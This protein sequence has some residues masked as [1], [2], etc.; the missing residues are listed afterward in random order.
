MTLRY[1]ALLVLAFVGAAA[2]P[3]SAQSLAHQRAL[4]YLQRN[5]ARHG[6][7]E[8]DVTG[9]VV[10]DATTSRRSGVTHVY[11]RQQ[12]GGVPVVAGAMTVNVARDGRVLLASGELVPALALRAPR[13]G[14][15]ISPAQAAEALAADIG[16]APTE[17]FSTVAAKTVGTPG[18]YLSDGGVSREPV[19]AS[20][21]YAADASGALRLAYEVQ[22]AERTAPLVWLGTVDAATGQVLSRV[23]LVIHDAFDG[24]DPAAVAVPVASPLVVAPALAPVLAPMLPVEQEQNAMGGAA[25]RVYP[26]PVI[27]PI[28]TAPLPPADA[29]STV[30]GIENATAS[31]Y[32]WHDTNGAAG[33]EH[34]TTRGNNAWAYT[35][36]SDN[37]T[38]DPSPN[39][40]PD[41]GAALQFVFPLDLAQAPSAYRPAAVTN[42]F[43]WSNLLHD[44]Y[45]Q[46][47]FDEAGGN[48]QANQYGRGGATTDDAVRSEAQDGSGTNNA[49]FYT[50]ID[51]GCGTLGCFPRM[52]MY[53][54]TTPTP[55]VDG[56]FDN[57]VIAHEY[58]HGLS[59]RLTGGP[60]T[61]CL[62]NTEQMGEGWS[63][64]YGLMVTMDATDTRTEARTVGN[65]LFGQGTTGAGIRPAPYSTAFTTNNY[66]YQ[67]TRTAVAPHG[68]GFIWA[69][70]LWEATW[71]MIAAYGFSPD[72]YNADGTAGNQIM[73][74]LVTEAL[75]MQPC[76]P[77]FVD[78]RNA[79]LAADEALYN[80][81]HVD[82]LWAAF[83]RRGLGFGANQGSPD[84]NTD[85]TES[86]I[87]P[88]QVAPAAITDLAVVPNGDY[89]R[90]TFTATGDDGS[91][92]T[93][94][95]YRVRRS[96]APIL[97]DA[98]YEAATPVTVVATPAVAGTAEAI[99]V[100]GLAFGTTYHFA[101]K[102]A[103]ESFNLSALSNS[104]GTT[105]LAA[106]TATVPSGPIS[107][108]TSGEATAML[109]L[110]NAGPSDLR[111][112]LALEETT[113]RTAPAAPTG[114]AVEG[115]EREKDNDP[116]AGAAQLRGS[117]GPDA[118]GYRW[119]DS[120]EPGG[121]AYSWVD[122][123]TTGTALAFSDDD[124]ETV[125]LPFAFPYYGVDQSTVTISSNGNLQFGGSSTAYSNVAI[126]N[127]AVPNNMVA[128]FWDDLNPS[129]TGTVKYQNMG[130]GRFIVQ[131][132]NVPRYTS[133]TGAITAQVILSRSGAIT[134]QYQAVPTTVNSAT[135]GIENATGT[136]GL[137][138]AFDGAYVAANL[139]VRISALWVET[140][141]TAGLIPAGQSRDVQLL[142]DATGL[143]A[144]TYTA[145][146]TV[147]TNSPNAASTV[148]PVTL[149]VGAVAA[150]AGPL[151][152]EG[153]HLLGA[154][155]PNPAPGAS[156]VD[157]AVAEAQTVRVELYDALGRR[158]AVVFDGPVAARTSVPVEVSS[159]ALAA[160]TY[161]LRVVGETF[162][163]ARRVTVVR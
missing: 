49:N 35:D 21:V 54:G 142:F 81:D 31:P 87:E 118:F 4:D 60:T 99:V 71:V 56:D 95:T 154:V 123:S 17:S 44:I 134:L 67:R 124:T 61:E 16:L 107:V 65:Y 43:Y 13:G 126:P 155:Y 160:G 147:T 12:I 24:D 92:G 42:L 141:V 82:L 47:G 77:G 20:L 10:T 109:T 159:G 156:R 79:I 101:L 51:G 131:Y 57:H 86:F 74:N 8:A 162:T 9:L 143:T 110:S 25:Y 125:P 3:A 122:I 52:Q 117:G 45:Y 151:A 132:T 85:N 37:D 136:D 22:I 108:A 112:S 80:G 116:A 11:V 34:T 148:I 6:L 72:V 135:V 30:S 96:A 33:A 163:D 105:T 39:G 59:K 89:A 153:T 78:G 129:S 28:Y 100:E 50:P 146:L 40:S 114:P 115:V 149:Q 19:A 70:A 158:V 38:P 138:V 62:R 76:S 111:F 5:S 103:D 104:A 90:L 152:F 55:D 145:N 119:T 140:D 139:A 14:A 120:N 91:V 7:T 69:T 128:L 26:Y 130:D 157:L 144:G 75:K 48:F 64:W 58:T 121:P 83:A 15:S 97:T 127:P 133:G 18:V 63:D 32:G 106:P 150:D 2:A 93:A 46:Y 66:T 98:D 41:G 94:A 73:L 161:V 137:Q 113:A 1:A 36:V 88:E 68:V 27:S 29:R 53:V 102:V 84:S 23:D